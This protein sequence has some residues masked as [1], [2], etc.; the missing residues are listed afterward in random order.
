M[1]PPLQELRALREQLGTV[2]N[3]CRPGCDPRT[4][5]AESS[6]SS[7]VIF[8]LLETKHLDVFGDH[9]FCTL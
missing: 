3:R 8:A 7:L 1:A 4:V 6:A 2:S 9:D 5:G